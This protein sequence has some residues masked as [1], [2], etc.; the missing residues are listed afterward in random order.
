MRVLIIEI[1]KILAVFEMEIEIGDVQNISF[2][3][4]YLKRHL[5]QIVINNHFS[6]II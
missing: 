2:Y 5:K 1:I 3:I 4:L 6:L